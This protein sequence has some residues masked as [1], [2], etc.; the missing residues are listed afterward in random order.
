MNEISLQLN[1]YEDP[2]VEEPVIEEPIIE[3]PEIEIPTTATENIV[4]ADTQ[5]WSYGNTIVV[6]NG[7]REIQIVD[8][9]GRAIKTIK[10]NN[11]RTEIPMQQ[12]GIYIVKS[13]LATQKVIIR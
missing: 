3:E 10:T 6:E 7:G 2:V 9:S 11:Q 1:G 5:I 12:P 4:P 13:G 8:I